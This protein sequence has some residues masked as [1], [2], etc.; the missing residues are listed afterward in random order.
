MEAFDS[1]WRGQEQTDRW[2]V[3]FHADEFERAKI[4]LRFSSEGHI[5]TLN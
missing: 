2:S 5:Y 4:G 1:G 3:M